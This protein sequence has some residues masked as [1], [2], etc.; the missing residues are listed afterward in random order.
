M[1]HIALTDNDEAE[2]RQHAIAHYYRYY[3]SRVRSGAWHKRV[4]DKLMDIVHRKHAVEA[5]AL[6]LTVD[7]QTVTLKQSS[8]SYSSA[9]R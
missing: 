1:T 6:T 7:G 8:Y 5:A 3:Y 9:L 4:A 2:L